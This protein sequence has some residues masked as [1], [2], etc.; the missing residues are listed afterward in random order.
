MPKVLELE[1][2][3]ECGAIHIPTPSNFTYITPK[4]NHYHFLVEWVCTTCFQK[5]SD[6]GEYLY[7]WL[8]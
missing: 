8:P 1:V 4:S 2:R 5:Q 7:S 3:C 6:E